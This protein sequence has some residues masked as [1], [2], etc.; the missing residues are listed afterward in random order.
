MEKQTMKIGK[1]HFIF[2]ILIKS[3]SMT[4]TQRSLFVLKIG[5]FTFRIL[6]I[7]RMS[8]SCDTTTV[9]FEF[10]RQ[11]RPK[12]FW[13]CWRPDVTHREWNSKSYFAKKTKQYEKQKARRAGA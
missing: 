4:Y 10:S 1:R 2:P 12:Q 6:P 7:L 3:G 9:T 13:I 8:G 11:D 5:S